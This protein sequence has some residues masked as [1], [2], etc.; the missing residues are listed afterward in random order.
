MCECIDTVSETLRAQDLRL[1]SVHPIS[2]DLS[3][4]PERVALRLERISGSRKQKP[5]LSASYCPFCGERY[6][7][8]T[9]TSAE[10]ES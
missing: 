1:V 4:L 9:T 8:P 7:H 2:L 6:D 3:F 5:T 10:G